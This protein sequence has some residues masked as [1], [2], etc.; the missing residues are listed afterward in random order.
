MEPSRAREQETYNAAAIRTAE[1][2]QQA[3]QSLRKRLEGTEIPRDQLFP[4]HN[5]AGLGVVLEYERM[6]NQPV[7][8]GLQARADAHGFAL[9]HLGLTIGSV[10]HGIDL[11]H[12]P[13][14]EVIRFL[15]DTLLE[16]KVIFFRD[17][18]LSEDEQV[19]FGRRFGDLDAFPFG[20]PGKN[21]YILEIS[22]GKSSPGTENSW[23]TDVTWMERPSLGSIAQCTL[24]PP[25][26]GDTLFSDSHAA[27][28]GLPDEWKERL[29]H[30][31]G[32]ND[33]RVF[34]TTR[35]PGVSDELI[36]AVKQEIPFGVSHPLLR[37]HPET[38]KTALYIHGGFLRH[39]SLYDVRSGEPLEKAE[40]IKI[41]RT[42]LQQHA[43]P[44]YHCRFHWET[45]SVAF[46]DNR[47]TQHYAASD[48]Y[49]HKRRLR[50]V[51]VS[52]DKPF[53]DARADSAAQLSP[54]G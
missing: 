53:Y 2:M 3:R 48:Y 11:E 15:R 26:G 43:R 54:T 33:Y 6:G 37:T 5:L 47:A 51:T 21:P 1:R 19:A 22:H 12:A 4:P 23:H 28:L 14:E 18:N 50:R 39:D 9:E 45:G 30:L 8:D 44:E 25:V 16:R 38:G 7:S 36:E 17:Q 52:G 24:V 20:P 46:W 49:P 40:S 32:I 35:G 29:Q 31:H 10:I 34:L 27:Y 41:V 13:S 42:L